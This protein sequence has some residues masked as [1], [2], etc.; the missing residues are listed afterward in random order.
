[1]SYL[2]LGEISEHLDTECPVVYQLSQ[3]GHIPCQKNN[4]RFR[5][6]RELVDEWFNGYGRSME[7][8]FKARAKLPRI[9]GVPSPVM[10]ESSLSKMKKGEP[11]MFAG[12]KLLTAREVATYLGTYCSVIYQLFV[13]GVIPCQKVEEGWRYHRETIDKWFDSRGAFMG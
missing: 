8:F 2:T 1:M 13:D 5:Y 11:T 6:H 3:E 7:E 10:L 4:G 12:K 9:A